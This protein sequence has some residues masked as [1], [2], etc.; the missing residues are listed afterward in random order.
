MQEHPEPVVLE[1]CEASA[2]TLDLL[3]TEVLALGWAVRGT[4]PV[5]VQDLF[6]PSLQGVTEGADLIDVIGPTTGDGLLEQHGGFLRIIGEIDVTD[7][8]FGQPGT[9]ELVVRITDAQSEQQTVLSS[10][11]EPFGPF[12]QELPDPIERVG[13]PA[14]VPQR[15]VL[16]PAAHLVDAAVGTRTTWKGSA[17]RM[18]W[19]RWGAVPAR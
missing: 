13:L 19:S 12:E 15:L 11:V 5:M 3:H 16:D 14:P 8:L 2:R 9:E 1:G 7:R 18:A 4:G 6:S 10:L 17:T